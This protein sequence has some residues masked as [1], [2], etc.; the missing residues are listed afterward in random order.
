LFLVDILQSPSMSQKRRFETETTPF[1]EQ[2]VNL[3]MD[4]NLSESEKSEFVDPT[5]NL[6]TDMDLT[7]V[8]DKT[9]F[10]SPQQM[11]TPIMRSFSVDNIYS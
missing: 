2:T 1:V 3:T 6:T 4:M 8:G 10:F 11:S 7:E 5:I 9:R